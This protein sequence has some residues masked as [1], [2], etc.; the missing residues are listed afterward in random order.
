M[1][2]SPSISMLPKVSLRNHPNTYQLGSQRPVIKKRSHQT[3]Q[4]PLRTKIK[5][6]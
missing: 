5:K 2:Y 6:K 4:E 1:Y 3:N